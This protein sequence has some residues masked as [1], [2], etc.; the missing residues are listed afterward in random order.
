MN[1]NTTVALFTLTALAVS[2]AHASKTVNE[3]RNAEP[4]ASVDINCVS[5]NLDVVGWDKLSV[6]V[7]GTVGND[8][9]RV[10]VTG[11]PNHISVQVVSRSMRMW[12]S[13]SS[14]HLTVHVP[15]GATVAPKLVSADFKVSGLNGDLDLHTVSGESQ[16]ETGGNLRITS[17]S[18]DVRIRAPAAKSLYVHSISGDIEVSGGNGESEVTTVSGTVRLKLGSQSKVYFKS[19]SGDFSASLGLSNDADVNAEVVSGDITLKLAAPAAADYDVVTHSG[20]ISNCF[21]PKPVEPQYGPGS[22]LVFKNGDSA[23]HVHIVTHSGDVRL[24]TQS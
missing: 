11:D 8:V 16:G 9:E 22:K 14:A 5:G 12:G 18:G 15:A 2:S 20:G 7:T 10:D 4:H 1:W 17:V 23:A 21:G 24:C 19:V 13:D 6:E 3:Q